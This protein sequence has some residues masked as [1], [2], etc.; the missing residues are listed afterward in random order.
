M[1]RPPLTIAEMTDIAHKRGGTCLSTEYVN[2]DTKLKWQ[3][4]NGHIW[5]A[6][7]YSVKS[8]TWCM[9]CSGKARKTIEEM[10]DI[11]KNRGGKCLSDDYLGYKKKLKWKCSLGHEWEATPGSIYGLKT[12][13]PYCAGNTTK[14]LKDMQEL[15]IKRGGKCLSE[16]YINVDTKYLWMCSL[17][18]E[19]EATFNKISHGQWCPTCSKSGISEEVARTAFEQMTGE[20][21]P[22]KRPAWLRNSRGYQMEFDGYNEKLRIAFEYQGIQHFDVNTRYMKNKA[23]LL[24]RI[25]DDK[26]KMSLA[27]EHK[28]NLFIIDYRMFY[29]DFPKN[30]L[31]QAKQMGINQSV[32]IKTHDIDF[33]KA[34]VRLDR[35][36]EIKALVEGRN[37]RLISNKWLGVKERYEV[38]CNKCGHEWSVVGSELIAGAWCRKCARRNLAEKHKGDLN[39]LIKYADRFGGFVLSDEYVSA[40]SKYLFKCKNGHKFTAKFNNLKFRN[41]WCPVCEGRIIRKGVLVY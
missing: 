7:P 16:E 11:A 32:F 18:H 12:W 33:H 41:Q 39:D 22:K 21:F 9:I 14:T 19:W 28:V 25:E 29:S 31:S 35:I 20:K 13:C 26:L 24:E 6:I 36:D 1:G 10:R 27:K 34:Y 23:K 40:Q 5:E 2:S 15:A 37:G 3:C 17:G 4:K 8:G 30:I 38:H